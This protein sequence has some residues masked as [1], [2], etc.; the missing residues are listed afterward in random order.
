MSMQAPAPGSET[1][2]RAA[3]QD[4]DGAAPDTA[5]VTGTD[6]YCVQDLPDSV[7]RLAGTIGEFT[8]DT[9][10]IHLTL[11]IRRL[12]DYAD[13]N[14]G[15]LLGALTGVESPVAAATNAGRRKL[16]HTAA[17]TV[18]GITGSFR[19][20]GR[21]AGGRKLTS[22]NIVE[23]IDVGVPIGLAYDLWTRFADWPEFI[24][25]FEQVRDEKLQWTGKVF[26]SRRTWESTILEQ[27][28]FDRIVWRSTGGKGYL[29]GA[30]SF[31]KLA[32][33]L[34]RII[35]VLEYHPRGL[36]EKTANLWR[37]VGRRARLE[38][39]HFARH[40]MTEAV[41]H[42]D[43]ITGWHGEIRHSEV[44]EDARPRDDTATRET[45]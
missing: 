29:D 13:G 40:A 3:D 21:S 18:D 14:G 11:I 1:E 9:V 37:A 10:S 5:D 17:N 23:Q 25:K 35:L 2:H 43:D 38:L 45:R 41:L 24:K 34:T 36:F 7:A 4:A 26:W 30:V 33:N 12:S 42:P 20:E 19:G 39:R 44:V 8:A 27:V 22:T 32:D 6:L 31:H 15:T 28:P 16:A